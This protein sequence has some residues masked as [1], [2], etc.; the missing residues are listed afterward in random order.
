M[1]V[2]AAAWC[3]Y[4]FDCMD[5][6][7]YTY[8]YMYMDSRVDSERDSARGASSRLVTGL[9]NKSIDHMPRRKPLLEQRGAVLE[10]AAEICDAHFGICGDLLGCQFLAS[11][12]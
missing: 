11:C 12:I 6:R 5:V 9:G 10:E 4:M 3:V 8:M 1:V 2:A 7:I